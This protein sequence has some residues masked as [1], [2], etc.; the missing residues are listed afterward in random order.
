LLIIEDI[1]G[2]VEGLTGYK[3]LKRKRNTNGE[4]ILS[5]TVF[6]TGQNKHSFQMVQ[7]ESVIKFDG[8]KYRIK[9]MSE[10]P[11]GNKIVKEV[12][13]I[14]TLFDLIDD[15]QYDTY[16]GS[17]TFANALEFIL[18]GTGYTW[19]IIGTFYA[20][21]WDNFGDDNR[22]ALFQDALKRYGAEFTLTDTHF[23][24]K[25]KIGNKTDFQ[26]RYNYN[27]KT[28]NR[29]VNT[30][31]FSTYIKGYGKQNEDGTYVVESEYI[32][33]LDE[34]N[35][36]PFKRKH[37]KPVRDDKY[38]T[39]EGLN[40]RLQAEL[41]DVPEVSIT[42]DFVDM[43]RAGYPFDVPNEGDDIFIIYEP[44]N[45]LD[46]EARIMEIEEWF[47]EGDPYPIQTNATLSNYQPKLVN[48]FIEY[49]RTQKSVTGILEGKKK[50]PFN[51]LDSAVQQTT[52]K[53]QSTETEIEYAN[54]FILRSK[55]NPNF[56]VLIN[57]A[58][59]G[60]SL[61]GGQT[62]QTALTAEG[63]VAD[64]ITSGTLR[65]ILIEGV[66]IIGSLF[67]SENNFQ[68]PYYY[69]RKSVDIENAQV[70]L[71]TIFDG[72]PSAEYLQTILNPEYLQ[73]IRNRNGNAMKET[74]VED[75]KVTLFTRDSSTGAQQSKLQL[76]TDSSSA[77][78]YVDKVIANGTV[79][80][81]Q[82]YVSIQRMDIGGLRF[83]A[84][85]AP[86]VSGEGSMWYGNGFQGKGLY[87][88]NAAGWLKIH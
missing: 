12:I 86:V 34:A 82:G 71:K 27:I 31:N 17:M 65:A 28:I 84:F 53:L 75:G 55:D 44:M 7:E 57:S 77:R 22:I 20:Q 54:G 76:T 43:R 59:I 41:N 81:L 79:L 11:R 42:V 51:S 30:N 48:R 47:S 74:L 72:H 24:F 46:L 8:D 33:P 63:I 16:T 52:K 38:T 32:S 4:R 88:Y 1:N 13:A 67:H 60:V 37:A 73:V 2:N 25:E 23:T 50:I 58:G 69:T 14:R 49:S 19:D 83:N 10:K 80:E 3:V 18:G 68:G 21:D 87:L 62:F 56:I 9:Q 6:P 39:L 15:Y 64:L 40:E 36:G 26:L 5:F 70:L 61:D 45:N 66:E 85:E 35:G 78:L 29:Q